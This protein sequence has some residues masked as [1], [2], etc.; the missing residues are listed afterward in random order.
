[1]RFIIDSSV[2]TTF[3][4]IA[5]A[6]VRIQLR[7]EARANADSLE[8]LKAETLGKLLSRVSNNADLEKFDTIQQWFEGYKKMGLRPKK[9]KPTHYAFTSRLVKDRRWPRAIGPLVDAYLVNQASHVMPHGGFDVDRLPK[10]ATTICLSRSEAETVFQPLGVLSGDSDKME[11][12]KPGEIIYQCLSDGTGEA[13]T[14]TRY[15]NYR[16]AEP[17]KIFD[18]PDDESKSTRDF[19][20]LIESLDPSPQGREKLQTTAN[21]LLQTY[22]KVYGQENVVQSYVRIAAGGELASVEEKECGAELSLDW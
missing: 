5:V 20:L 13:L 7:T 15:L 11:R 12:T 21:D 2:T 4:Y 18:D 19:V 14:L 6:W 10:E 3:P 9:V 22:V 1:M 16:D 8:A 17:S